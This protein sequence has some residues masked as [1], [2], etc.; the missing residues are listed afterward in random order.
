[1]NGR[2]GSWNG[3]GEANGRPRAGGEG[4]VLVTGGAGFVGTNL[5]DRLADGDSRRLRRILMTT[6][7]VGGVW[8]YAL[9]LAAGLGRLG[10]EVHLATLG[11]PPSP[12]QRRAAK[13]LG[14][15]EL[16]TSLFRLEWMRD[17]WG[18]VRTS[19][20]WL[21]ALEREI[22]PD[23]VHL[24]QYAFGALPFRAPSLVAGHSCVYSWWR[25]VHGTEPPAEWQPYRRV[26]AQGLAGADL[27]VAPTH[28][29]LRELEELYGLSGPS[30]VIA[31]G[32]S[33]AQFRPAPQ[34]EPFVLSVGRLWDEAKNLQALDRAA[35][36]LPWKVKV[37][38]PVEHP[39]GGAD[40]KARSPRVRLLGRLA[41]DDLSGW[42]ARASIYALPA[43]YEPF[44]LSV[45]E[46]ALSGCALVLGD[47]PS[48]RENWDGMARFVDPE[49]P[50]ELRRALR[51]LVDDPAGRVELASRARS[52]ALAFAPE[53]QAARYLEAYARLVHAKPP[54]G[55]QAHAPMAQWQGSRPVQPTA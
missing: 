54:E 53:R 2:N 5:A 49:D 44:G 21:L 38:G 37:A 55:L 12:A 51:S 28:A 39:D 42:F 25:A 23:L 29:M 34:K 45:L 18:D 22:R 31:N 17:S 8:T 33:P 32:R 27:V 48:L 26:V 46:A 14:N 1:M 16:Y 40:G 3:N 50:E 6:D 43:R 15:V 4:P 19:G 24:N 30:T 7:T 41:P 36:G 20:E 13:R 52:R 11:D 47:I 9:E 10:L 35:E